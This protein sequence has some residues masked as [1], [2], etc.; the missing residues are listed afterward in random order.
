M[1][2]S[3]EK[4]PGLD[5]WLSITADGKVVV[6]SGKVDIGQRISTAMA[7]IVADELDVALERIDMAPVETG[8]SPDEGVTSGSNSM[9]DSGQA[10]RLAAA[11]ARRHLIEKAAEALE[12]DSESL[13][14]ADGLIRSRDTNR[15]V[16]YWDLQGDQPFD[17]PID[18]EVPVKAPDGYSE[19]G[20]P[21]AARGLTDLVTGQAKFVHDMTLPGMRKRLFRAPKDNPDD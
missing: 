3:L 15:S 1:T 2:A 4:Q 11:T 20:K 14:L 18:P 6:H 16:T 9:Q 13:E 10:V 7:A 19:V 12:V 17:I 21:Q 8:V 5:R